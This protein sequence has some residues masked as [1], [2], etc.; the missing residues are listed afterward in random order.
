M[1]FAAGHGAAGISFWSW[2]AANQPAWN[3]IR[4]ASEFRTPDPATTAEATSPSAMDPQH[5]P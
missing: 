2:Q 1:R 4:E 5:G 3:T